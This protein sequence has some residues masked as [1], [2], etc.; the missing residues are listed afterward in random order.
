[1]VYRELDV[2]SLDR[3]KK[4]G[5][6]HV[7]LDVREPAECAVAA[8]DGALR[9]PMRELPQRI[10]EIPREKPVVV[11]CHVGERSA[12]VASFLLA[13]GFGDVYNLEGG[14]DAYSQIVDPTIPRY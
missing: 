6:E 3:W 8:I 2:A 14:I 7:L 10:D 4:T 9:I 13:S 12:R 1:M 11:M 5:A